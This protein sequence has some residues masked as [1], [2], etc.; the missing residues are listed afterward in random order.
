[1]KQIPPAIQKDH[2]YLKFK[3][4]GKKKELGEVVEAVWK[5]T[6]GYLGTR[7]ASKADIW[8]IG[9]RFDEKNQT[10]VIK[11]SK[12]SED[13]IRAALT[14]NPGFKDDTFLSVEKVSGT[15]ESL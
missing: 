13:N 5:S 6:T 3:I 15:I 1:M 10:G 7:E 4:R 11:T 8:I 2:R 9:N 12:E 14:V